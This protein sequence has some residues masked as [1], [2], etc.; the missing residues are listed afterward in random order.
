MCLASTGKRKFLLLTFFLFFVYSVFGEVPESVKESLAAKEALREAAAK[1]QNAG[2]EV[3]AK[4]AKKIK[5][6]IFVLWG[7]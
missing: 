7:K 6:G 3:S 1:Q 4:D 2:A 5:V